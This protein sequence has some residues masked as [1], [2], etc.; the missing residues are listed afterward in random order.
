ML[1]ANVMK[2]EVFRN[3]AIPVQMNVKNGDTVVILTDSKI[4]P[5]IQEALFTA[6]Y[7]QKATPILVMIPPLESFGNEPPAAAAACL[8]KAD[9]VISAC[10]TAMTHTDAIREALNAGARYLA[11]GGITVESLTQGAA[12][13]DYDEVMRLSKKIA[14]KM[15]DSKEVRITSELG[16][17]LR[18]SIEGRPSFP[19]C[20][21]IEDIRPIAAFP[22][23]EV[24]VAPVEGKANGKIVIDGTIHHV[25][26]ITTPVEF[27]IE[28]GTVTQILG[29][30]EADR[31]RHF[32]QE[33]GDENSL[34]LAEFAFGTNRN[35][36]LGDNPQ[37][38]KKM[39]GTIHVAIGDNRTLAGNTY[40]KTHLDCLVLKPSVWLDD[41]LVVK[42]GKLLITADDK[43]NIQ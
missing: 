14:Q 20:G 25:G 27:M 34:N 18:F 11:L 17:D 38:S 22:D 7:H 15:D 42:N 40:S 10:S 6:V 16:T 2:L 8:P 12:T 36:R 9:I 29:G 1:G 30:E 39:L 37:E 21:I 28:N 24:A 23:G 41:E 33:K 4:D 3:A 35:A 5:I 31:L 43:K 26:K 19:L 32:L 13:A